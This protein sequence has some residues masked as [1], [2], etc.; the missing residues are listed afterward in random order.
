[1]RGS[2][3][4]NLWPEMESRVLA[5]QVTRQGVLAAVLSCVLTALVSALSVGGYTLYNFLDALIFAIV[6]WRIYRLSFSWSI[7]GLVFFLVERID[8]VTRGT[9]K[10]NLVGWI[11]AAAFVMCY[12]NS[13]RATWFLR[14]N[15]D[16]QV[17][18]SDKAA[19]SS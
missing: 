2:A 18:P 10:I 14:K 8:G 17:E 5:I 15:K 3:F 1:M 13:I 7:F 16:T 19:I 12:V 6:A 9:I 4:W 11:I